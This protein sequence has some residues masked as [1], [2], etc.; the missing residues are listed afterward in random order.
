MVS[1]GFEPLLDSQLPKGIGKSLRT[2][3]KT[4]IS[5]LPENILH[6]KVHG[7]SR[8]GLNLELFYFDFKVAGSRPREN[9]AVKQTSAILPL[10]KLNNH[11]D[12]VNL[13]VVIAYNLV[14]KAT[15]IA[16]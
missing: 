8:H 15:H 14:D 4:K 6:D 1:I 5:L 11:P 12:E 9:C 16:E 2:K 13:K 10:F 7:V 3:I